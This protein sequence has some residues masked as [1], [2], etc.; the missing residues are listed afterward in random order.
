MSGVK[1]LSENVTSNMNSD[2]DDDEETK[3]K[4][5]RTKLFEALD[6]HN[7]DEF[8]S[9]LQD[10]EVRKRIRFLKLDTTKNSEGLTL[11]QEASKLTNSGFVECLLRKGNVNANHWTENED[12]PLLIAARLGRW[13]VLKAFRNYNE[14]PE[15]DQSKTI[16]F[17]VWTKS[18]E[19]TVFHLILTRNSAQIQSRAADY[20]KCIAALVDNANDR[21]LEE[22]R[23]VVNKQNVSTG[24]TPL[25]FA[26]NSWPQ[27]VIK[28]LLNLGADV[29][30]PYKNF[31]PL[32]TK[33]PADTIS[34]Y[35]DEYC[36]DSS[37]AVSEMPE[38][39][40]ENITDDDDDMLEY[41]K[42]MEACDVS[43][44]DSVRDS[45]ITFNY[46]FLLPS[47]TISKMSSENTTLHEDVRLKKQETIP[48][49][50]PELLDKVFEAKKRKVSFRE[51]SNLEMHILEKVSESEKHNF[52]LTHPVIKSFLYLK[53]KKI[54]PI[55]ERNLKFNLL[56]VYC[57][58]WY[59]FNQFAGLEF[60]AI[61]YDDCR[62]GAGLDEVIRNNDKMTEFCDLLEAANN[63][64]KNAVPRT[65]FYEAYNL[66]GFGDDENLNLMSKFQLNFFDKFTLV[67]NNSDNADDKLYASNGLLAIRCNYYDYWYIGFVIISAAL[68][69]LS[70]VEL[71]NRIHG[72][73]KDE[74]SAALKS[75]VDVPGI[76]VLICTTLPVIV[77]SKELLWLTILII[78]VRSA[79]IE[80][81]QFV[82]CLIQWSSRYIKSLENYR[83]I[84]IIVLTSVILFLP[85]KS[86]ADPMSFTLSSNVKKLCET[87]HLLNDD[88]SF[89]ATG[90]GFGSDVTIKRKLSA[91]LIVLSW[92]QLMSNIALHPMLESFNFYLMMFRKVAFRFISLLIFYGFFIISFGLGFYIMFHNDVGDSILENSEAT[93][94]DAPVP[95]IMKTVA[96][97]IGEFEFGSMPIGIAHGRKDGSWSVHLAYLFLGLF[98]FMLVLVLNNLLNG[99]AVSDTDKIMNDAMILHHKMYID[100]LAYSDCI[101][102]SMKKFSLL[103]FEGFKCFRPF[104]YIFDTTSYL[105]MDSEKSV[106]RGHFCSEKREIEMGTQERIKENTL[107]WASRKLFEFLSWD[108]SDI[109]TKNAIVSEAK[110]ILIDRKKEEI[111]QSILVKSMRQTFFPSNCGN[112]EE[113]KQIHF[114][115]NIVNNIRCMK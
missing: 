93:V 25:H 100:I 51:K 82:T 13:K 90:V 65:K 43:F 57:I 53:W 55:Y 94:F 107:M 85:N 38:G 91:F 3:L 113:K 66:T 92:M 74:T 26:V 64:K 34:E 54:S 36:M 98:M 99:L 11:M 67:I 44:M 84:A 15:N 79:I 28:I 89:T 59:I 60:N 2:V 108:I 78:T 61:K 49:F 76:I 102:H 6:N 1:K 24:K 23:N 105:L 50:D 95:A 21:H 75:A 27:S 96:M 40:K 5:Y 16:D 97:F 101:V 109:E 18:N 63:E 104:L 47:N 46:R 106:Q 86:I 37:N 41:E 81:L 69:L 70:L 39:E 7:F 58:T 33:I 88:H 114:I 52:L 10:N 30:I 8:D 22:L 45:K 4:R 32:L 9:M 20:R 110:Q 31:S 48:S 73:I 17:A 71:K 14:D 62:R 115:Q 68:I 80:L 42:E 77:G 111:Q 103:I 19:D 29:S 112:A 35:F 12:R 56:F 83:D 72:H 87:S